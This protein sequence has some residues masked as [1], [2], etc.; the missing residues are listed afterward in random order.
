MTLLH[1]SDDIYIYILPSVVA[2]ETQRGLFTS[3]MDSV[4]SASFHGEPNFLQD[5]PMNILNFNVTRNN[6]RRGKRQKIE[7]DLETTELTFNLN[8]L[9]AFCVIYATQC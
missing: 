1:E 8:D 4:Y 9:N 2:G 6:S 7:R 5:I 3:I